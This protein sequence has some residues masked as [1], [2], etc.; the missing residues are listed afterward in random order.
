VVT[1]ASI[2]RHFNRMVAGNSDPF[3]RVVLWDRARKAAEQEAAESRAAAI[4][5]EQLYREEI[6]RALTPTTDTRTRADGYTQVVE[7]FAR[8]FGISVEWRAARAMPAGVR[9]VANIRKRHVMVPRIEG[10]ADEVEI[11]F[12]ISLHELG[13]C[14]EPCSGS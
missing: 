4:K 7:S 9:G 6:R 8:E 13:L 2:Q 3:Y 14:L 10:S 12:G 1:Q 5:K 11:A